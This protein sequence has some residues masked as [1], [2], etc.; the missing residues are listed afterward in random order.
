MHWA[1]IVAA[2]QKADSSLRKIAKEEGVT[3]AAVTQVIRGDRT[4]HRI[5]YA[6][7]A[8]TNIPTEKMWPGKYLEPEAYKKARRGK[9]AGRLAEVKEVVNG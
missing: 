8:K 6:I 4:S 5:A 2:I 9:T 1:D 7:A 3:P